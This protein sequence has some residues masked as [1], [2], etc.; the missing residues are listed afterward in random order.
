MTSVVAK[1]LADG[2]LTVHV[3]P[4][5]TLET[6]VYVATPPDVTPGKSTPIT[7]TATDARTGERK[8]V[9]DHFFAP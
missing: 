4:D 9:G 6:P 1:P 7:F 3:E 2:S 8:S 5:T